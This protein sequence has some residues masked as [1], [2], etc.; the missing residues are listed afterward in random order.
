[1]KDFIRKLEN[2][3]SSEYN[4]LKKEILSIN[5][6]WKY[7]EHSTNPRLDQ[8]GFSNN[9]IYQHPIV[10]AAD[11]KED[12]LIS[13]TVSQYADITFEVIRQIFSYNKVD[14]N[15][16]YRCVVN[17]IHYYDGKP[18]PLHL[19]HYN[20][21]H[22]NCLIYFNSFDNGEIDVYGKDK[23]MQRYKPL[24]DDIITFDGLYHSIHQ[25]APKQRRVVMVITYS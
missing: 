6:M 19:D 15:Q 22:K 9:P 3:L 10:L 8:E 5:F 18:S 11:A 17:Q 20:W 23:T 2:P 24:E 14:Y 1:M 21:D 4:I 16:I 13:Q 25:P 12:F 7:L